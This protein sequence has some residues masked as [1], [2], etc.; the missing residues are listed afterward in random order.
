MKRFILT[1]FCFACIT[2]GFAQSFEDELN[3]LA[4]AEMKSG[5][6]L[7]ELQVNPN[8]ANY[9]VTYHRL[10]FEVNPFEYFI[11]GS[12]TTH[13][14]ALEDM[15][16][17]TFDFNS[18]LTVSSVTQN[19]ANLTFT[20]SGDELII[21]FPA[22]VNEGEEGVVTI[23]YSGQPGF[24][25]G[26]FSISG[27]NG[28]PVL[29][30]LSE[31]YG[32]KDW[33]PCKQDLN[34]KI[35][36]I[37]V[38][39][40]APQ[41][42][43]SVSNGLEQ[44][45]ELDGEGSRTTHYRHEYP[46][47][48]YLIAIAVSN[49]SIYTQQAGTA[50]N[51]FP[52]VNYIYPENLESAQQELA[53]T[54]PIMDFYEDMFEAYPFHEEKYGHAQCNINGGMEHTTVSFMTGFNRNLIAHELAHQWF[55]NKVTCGSWSDIWLN[56]GFAT[57]LSGLVI[58]HLDGEFNFINWKAE[59][60]ISITSAPGGSVY[61][62]EN[63]LN[64]VGRIF[65]SR[66]SYNKGAM[67]VHML[68][69]KL[70]DEDFYQG[71]RNYLADENLA[72]DYAVTP[73]LQ[74]HLEAASG[75]DLTEFFN[76]WVYNEGYPSYTVSVEDLGGGQVE[77]TLSQTQSHPSVSYFEM[78]VTVRLLSAGGETFD[79]VLENTFNNQEF[80]VNVPFVAAG[81]QVDPKK[82]IICANS[83]FLDTV[84]FNLSGVKLYPN[85]VK[86]ILKAQLP[87]NVVVQKAVFYNVLGKKEME[88]TAE[89]QWDVSSLPSGLHFIKLITSAGAATFKFI[90]E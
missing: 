42:Y 88:A 36:S 48:A 43:V 86:D 8:T 64:D 2:A 16:D 58:E 26:A 7:K 49:Y 90:K 67:V 74:N 17:I 10:E 69:Y 33:W 22:T 77:I 63:Q 12:V 51:T 18:Q 75:M 25:E 19:E 14:T 65:S 35:D 83:A 41:Q 38:F 60:I 59:R 53:V 11:T 82:D 44:S 70:G 24:D 29:W 81:A 71:V 55:G 3:A 37:D 56:E 79:V 61:V 34:D 4:D 62:P 87:E 47:P 54:L 72:F 46:I 73:D 78:P 85:P 76:D 45:Q 32:A 80:T 13:F 21:T 28:N 50:P 27:H 15:A 9:D 57:Y 39:I 40:T 1:L 52:I 6:K 68:R 66:L 5:I 23:N 20:Q 30:T 84:R 89:A 31:P